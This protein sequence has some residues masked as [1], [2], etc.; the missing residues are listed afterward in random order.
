MNDLFVKFTMAELKRLSVKYSYSSIPQKIKDKHATEFMRLY[1]R[2]EE[3]LKNGDRQGRQAILEEF[4]K[5]FITVAREA[6]K[7]GVLR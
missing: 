4:E 6:K 5:Y 7:E 1:D 2:L 3:C